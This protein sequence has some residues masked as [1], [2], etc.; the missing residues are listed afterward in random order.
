MVHVA[1]C[2]NPNVTLKL[3]AVRRCS[4]GESR[5]AAHD[6]RYDINI[7]VLDTEMYSN[8]GGQQSKATP[9]GASVKFA[10]GGKRFKK[11]SLALMAMQYEVCDVMAV[12][13]SLFPFPPRAYRLCLCGRET[14]RRADATW[15]DAPGLGLVR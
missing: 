12:T 5:P 6:H 13:S 7:L 1:G 8:T 10:L 3:T 2:A 4:T 15:T 9:M 11:K 14:A